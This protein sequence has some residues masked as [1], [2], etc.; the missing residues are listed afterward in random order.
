LFVYELGMDFAL[1]IFIDH[2][3]T[4]A[5]LEGTEGDDGSPLV[6]RGGNKAV[7]PLDSTKERYIRIK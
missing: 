1:N 6:V 2:Y 5:S 4:V 7:G 3:C